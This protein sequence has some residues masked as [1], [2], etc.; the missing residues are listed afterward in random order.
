MNGR[1]CLRF[2]IIWA[3][4][5]VCLGLFALSYTATPPKLSLAFLLT[6]K[7]NENCWIVTYADHDRSPGIRD[8]TCGHRTYDGHNGI[9][10]GIG[11]MRV[12]EAGVSVIAAADGVVKGIRNNE[13]DISIHVRGHEAVNGRECGNGVMLMHANGYS[14]Q[15]CHLKK[16]SV[17]V[18]PGQQV[19]AGET[20]G[21]VGLSGKTEL[22][23][24]HFTVRHDNHIIDPFT[25][26]ELSQTCKP[27]AVQSPLWETSV[28]SQL[29]YKPVLIY[30]AGIADYI[31]KVE[32][33]EVE[34]SQITT[35]SADSPVI[36]LWAILYGVEAGDVLSL[37]IIGPD[38]RILVDNTT[39][40]TQRN[41][42]YYK[43]LGK[44]KKDTR[45]APGLYRGRIILNRKPGNIQEKHSVQFRIF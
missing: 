15:Y 34:Q 42:R 36:V 44:R 24:L 6:C 2:G 23:H 28:I 14:T 18:K 11:N 3:I 5:A 17:S 20:L 12:M 37:Q 10:I 8:Y 45:W 25:G 22:P 43:Y 35:L 30:S 21:L 19:R 26:L 29:Q 40:L 39:V 13:P 41:V 1:F 38:G 31:P 4:A 32:E 9:D 33:I 27:S 16:G 7:P